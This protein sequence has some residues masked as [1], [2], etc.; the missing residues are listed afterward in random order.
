MS[1]K[2]TTKKKKDKAIDFGKVLIEAKK[3]DN[4]KK[5]EDL[6]YHVRALYELL[7]RDN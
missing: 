4:L 6:K 5:V 3:L 2:K 1:K 7:F